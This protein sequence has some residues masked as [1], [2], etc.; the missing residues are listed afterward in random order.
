M[1]ERFERVVR[2][3]AGHLFTTNWMPWVSLKAVRLGSRRWQQCP[4][5]RH[6]AWVRPVVP[7]ALSTEELAEARSV[8][9]PRLP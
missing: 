2:C 4:V 9:D 8:H 6:W 3:D 5:G 1:L 7:G